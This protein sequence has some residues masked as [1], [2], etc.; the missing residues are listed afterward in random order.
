[1]L[2]ELEL[3][4]HKG[5]LSSLIKKQKGMFDASRKNNNAYMRGEFGSQEKPKGQ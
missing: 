2:L 3:K 4:K 1:M 5:N